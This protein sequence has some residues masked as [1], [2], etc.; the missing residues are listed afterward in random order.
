[1]SRGT[2]SRNS[3]GAASVQ[4]RWI[5]RVRQTFADRRRGGRLPRTLRRLAAAALIVAAGVVALWPPGPTDGEQLVAF[6]RD[7]PI[8]THLQDTDL[9]VVRT[10]LIPDGA[11]HDPAA[12]IGREL[13]ARARRGEVVTDARLTEQLGPD[14][15]PGRVAV[16]VR[17]ADP[18]IIAL[19]DTGM[20]VAVIAVNEDGSTAALAPDAVVLAIAP[21]PDR[22]SAD[23][24]IVLAIPA[25]V[26]DQVVAAALSGTIALRFT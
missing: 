6:S 14:P 9:E 11:V 13:A 12:L 17:P 3:N 7:L 25:E 10:R 15:G 26:A 19:L 22:G 16:P 20:H 2:N 1:M 5:D 23:R 4:P 8:G 18:S 21:A 24:P